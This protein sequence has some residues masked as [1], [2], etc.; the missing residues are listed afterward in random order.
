M[1]E[2]GNFLFKKLRVVIKSNLT[3]LEKGKLKGDCLTSKK[4]EYIQRE[5]FSHQL[6]FVTSLYPINSKENKEH[7]RFSA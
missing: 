4:I 3:T 1:N 6:V 7:S 5:L 2:N